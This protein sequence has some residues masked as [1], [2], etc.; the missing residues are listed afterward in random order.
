MSKKTFY[1]LMSV[2]MISIPG[3]S[4]QERVVKVQNSVRVGYDDN[5]YLQ[6]DKE[7]SAFITDILTLT[8][9]FNLSGRTD[10]ILYW[11]PEVRYRFDADPETVSYQDL[12]AKL[13]HAI[14]ERTS[15]TLSDRFRYQIK[16]GQSGAGVARDNQNYLENALNGAVGIDTSST[17]QVKLG[18]GYELRRWDDA[19]YGSSLQNDYDQYVLDA[20]YL[21]LLNQNKTTGILSGNYVNHE[22]DGNRGGYE[23]MS[24]IGGVDQ[25]FNPNL[26]GF[27]R[28]G[29][30]A[31]TID[32]TSSSSTDSTSPYLDAGLNYRPS[33]RTSL[34]GSFGYS[35]KRSENS[36]YNAQDE[37]NL[38]L[39]GRHDLTG[40]ISV[41]GSVAYI[42]S[43]YKGDYFYAGNGI[44]ASVPDVDDTF[45]RVNLRATYQIN[46]NNFVEAGYS[47]SDRST[48]TISTLP[49]YD[50]S[51]VD[52]GWRLR[53]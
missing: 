31:A 14:S 24:L 39:G 16:D 28:L 9:D 32:N 48:D 30:T 51:V 29:I 27:G 26:S 8:G 22:Y 6:N 19:Q 37:F 34:D 5:I 33:E 42:L 40:K 35:L 52:I 46:R 53:L 21:L 41:A 45:F 13:D 43:Q 3:F 44:I 4:A 20:S 7:G 23:A 38:R 1:V 2:S 25:T 15:L 11:Q 49:E 50:R 47:Y 17:G 36:F 12:Y 18:A 10:A